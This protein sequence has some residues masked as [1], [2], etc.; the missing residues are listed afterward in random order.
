MSSGVIKRSSSIRLIRN[1]VVVHEGEL[2]SLRRF[3]DDVREVLNG[4]E[5]GFTIDKYN[6]IKIDDV[7][8]AFEMVEI[9]RK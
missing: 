1:G 9:E 5:F 3:D 7:I 8:E 6:D 4:F 2:G